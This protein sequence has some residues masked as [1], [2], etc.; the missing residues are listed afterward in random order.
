MCFGLLTLNFT[1]EMNN[2]PFCPSTFKNKHTPEQA[3]L[4][5][6][7]I[8]SHI[9]WNTLMMMFLS[10]CI[11]VNFNP[12]ETSSAPSYILFIYT[13][14]K[15]NH[16]IYTFRIRS[17]EWFSARI[18]NWDC[19]AVHG[20]TKVLIFYLNFTSELNLHGAKRIFAAAYKAFR[21]RGTCVVI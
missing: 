10:N 18:S 8:R 7:N 16:V 13:T 20:R 9:R 15:Q 17:T 5:T 6:S 3:Q 12:S 19:L 14:R 1:L 21:M 4:N 2:R 11:L